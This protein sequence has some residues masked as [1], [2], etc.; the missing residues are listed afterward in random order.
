MFKKAIFVIATG[1]TMVTYGLDSQ[2]IPYVIKSGDSVSEVIAKHQLRPLYGVT[3][4]E[5]KVL[6]LNR[7]THNT[8]KKLGPGDVIV[9]P[10]SAKIFD[11]DQY[12]D[13]IST[14]RSSVM[15]S[16]QEDYYRDKENNFKVGLEYFVQDL[17]YEN[18]DVVVNQ[19]FR[20]YVEYQHKDVKA[21]RWAFEPSVT[22]GGYTQS[23][24]TF[25]DNTERS[26]DFSPSLFSTLSAEFRDKEYN[27]SIAPTVKFESFSSLH[28]DGETYSV[29]DQK[30]V[31]AGLIASK[32][33]DTGKNLFF[34]KGEAF[35][36]DKDTN[37]LI[38][39]AGVLYK[40]HYQVE[41]NVGK[42][43]LNLGQKLNIN[44]GA[45]GLAYKF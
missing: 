45:I 44:S 1:A 22:L 35:Y 4:W 41:I 25:S 19:N 17:N 26:A 13:E 16:V 5:A 37:E 20:F 33:F 21:Q 7:L 30:Y 9:L 40:K 42:K 31:W 12:E 24:A 15:K 29:K 32:Y 6:K 34:I 36:K 43:E 27:Y 39:R 14:V 8:A 18:V 23:Q 28:L 10:L 2:Y 11:N 38:A 3:N